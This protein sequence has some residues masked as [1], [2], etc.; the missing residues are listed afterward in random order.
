MF[1][2]VSRADLV[3]R[4]PRPN[5]ASMVRALPFQ[6]CSTRL[7]ASGTMVTGLLAVAWQVN[8]LAGGVNVPPR[9]ECCC[10]VEQRYRFA[11]ALGTSQGRELFG[12]RSG[13]DVVQDTG[14]EPSDRAWA[15]PFRTGWCPVLATGSC[16][17]TVRTIFRHPGRATLEFSPQE[18]AERLAATTPRQR[19]E[20]LLFLSG[21]APATF[22]A[23]LDAVE[24][25]DE[26]A[27][28]DDAQPACAECGEPVGIFLLLGLDWRHYRGQEPGGPF[29][30]YDP[31]HDPVL[32]RQPAEG[33]ATAS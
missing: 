30:I 18:R 24:P 23:A 10:G 7:D 21:Y 13:L 3:A 11:S 16:P 17:C 8:H 2:V 31:G 22:D 25:F 15:R 27:D 4:R 33:L 28:P 19:T 6:P 20:A 26:T 12:Y 9:A 29:E 5:F 1:P 32:T 14:P